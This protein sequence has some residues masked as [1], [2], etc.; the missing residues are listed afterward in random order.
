MR[1]ILA[2]DQHALGREAAALGG[3]AIREAIAARGHAAIVLATGASQFEMLE[4]LCQRTDIDWSRVTAFHLDEYI[5]L[6]E[7]HPA[8]FR[9]YLAERFLAHVPNIGAFHLIDGNADLAGELARLNG[10]IAPLAMDVVFAGIGE[11]GHLAFNDPPAD[12]DAE[13]GFKVVTLDEACRRQQLGEG[14]FPTLDAV[15]HQAISMTIRQIMRGQLVVLSVSGERKAAAVR[16]A[17]LGAVTPLCPAS[18]LQQHPNCHV[19]LDPPAARHL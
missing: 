9:R 19:F 15:P 18:I 12:F 7:T 11:N 2:A 16:D 3:I 13:D 4:A 10:L 8:S 17:V 5:D 1:M 6:P 14:W